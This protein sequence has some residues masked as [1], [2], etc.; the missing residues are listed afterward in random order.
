MGGGTVTTRSTPST[1]HDKELI[2]SLTHGGLADSTEMLLQGT[3][4]L[5][6]DAWVPVP[7]ISYAP[8][9]ASP[10]S[11]LPRLLFTLSRTRFFTACDFLGPIPLKPY[12][13]D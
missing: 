9:F 12:L 2:V 5:L 6:F 8:P 13:A 1:L 3:E 4:P 7:K 11:G 10:V